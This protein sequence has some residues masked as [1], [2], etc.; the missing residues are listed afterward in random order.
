MRFPINLLY[1]LKS[2]K[3]GE[4]NAVAHPRSLTEKGGTPTGVGFDRALVPFSIN[5]VL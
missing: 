3:S 1:T 4:Q 2:G 5:F